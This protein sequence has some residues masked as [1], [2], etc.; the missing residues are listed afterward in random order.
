M[1]E[2]RDVHSKSNY[3]DKVLQ[4]HHHHHHHHWE[5]KTQNEI[6]IKF[7]ASQIYFPTDLEP[8]PP[9]N[10]K[11]ATDTH[12]YI[13]SSP[14]LIVIDY[15]PHDH[16]QHDHWSPPSPSS[17]LFIVVVPNI[18]ID[19]KHLGAVPS[20]WECFSTFCQQ[21]HFNF[22]SFFQHFPRVT[23]TLE[24]HTSP[25]SS[26]S[27]ARLFFCHTPVSPSPIPLDMFL[28]F[29]H[30]S[31]PGRF[32]I[33]HSSSCFFSFFIFA[34]LPPQWLAN[35]GHWWMTWHISVRLSISSGVI[36][37][38]TFYHHDTISDLVH[39]PSLN[40]WYGSS[41][42]G[43]MF[44]FTHKVPYQD[45]HWSLHNLTPPPIKNKN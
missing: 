36:T 21:V 24:A 35:N 4:R 5:E 31:K 41:L 39:D 25:L 6:I 27:G 30:A 45:A 9:K 26:N 15:H 2:K 28:I 12:H 32:K 20:Y 3:T 13:I 23:F 42:K 29:T 11:N 1:E 44:I 10:D 38:L 8:N 17:S 34:P 37:V 43:F 18:I 33:L 14:W 7:S 19:R 16:H 40:N 22:H